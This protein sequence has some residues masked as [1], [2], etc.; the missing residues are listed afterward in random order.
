[1]RIVLIFFSLLLAVSAAQAEFSRDEIVW[2]YKNKW[3]PQFSVPPDWHGDVA[4]GDA[5]SISNA[6]KQATLE[7]INFVRRLEGL[8]L[9]GPFDPV[10]SA[11]CQQYALVLSANHILTHH[12]TPD[13]A[14][15]SSTVVANS[16][17]AAL[18]D[19]LNAH[20]H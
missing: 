1:M 18:R 11:L 5:G 7:T 9:E 3:L 19:R 17:V 15:Y 8:P 13:M 20:A 2:L 12:I 14:F 16:G 10:K 6:H 4:N